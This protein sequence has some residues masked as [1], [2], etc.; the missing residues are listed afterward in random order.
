M[1]AIIP[2]LFLAT[3]LQGQEDT[4]VWE[5]L[6]LVHMES[7]FDDMT[8][9]IIKTA[10]PKEQAMALD[11]TIVEISGYM[12][13]LDVKSE[14]SDFLFSRYT[15]NMCFFCGGAGP[16]TAMQVFMKDE[17]K[18]KHQMDKVRLRGKLKIQSGDPTGLIYILEDSE[19]VKIKK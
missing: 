5:T 6:A 4:N 8:A 1:K 12:I 17:K 3:L 16:E 7:K 15:Q 13:A 11:G 18:V 14:N 10:T 19:L 2:F 9:M